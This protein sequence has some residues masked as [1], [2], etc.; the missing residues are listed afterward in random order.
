MIKGKMS[1]GT[2]EQLTRFSSAA[3]KGAPSHPLDAE[4]WRDF[5]IEAHKEREPIYAN[6]LEEWLKSEG[7]RT[8]WQAIWLMITNVP[9]LC[10]GNTTRKTDCPGPGW[11]AYLSGAAQSHGAMNSPPRRRRRPSRAARSSSGILA[12]GCT[13]SAPAPVAHRPPREHPAG[14]LGCYN[15][16]LG[17]AW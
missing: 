6:D 4:R 11:L 2:F 5:V 16:K 10:S 17:A 7:S 9:G 1:E 13:L 14:V 15:A 12:A 3:N 8:T